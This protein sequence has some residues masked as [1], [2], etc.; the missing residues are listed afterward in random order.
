MDAPTHSCPPI[1][2]PRPVM[3]SI[4]P[5]ASP[6]LWWLE[7]VS[8]FYGRIYFMVRGSITPGIRAHSVDAGALA[9]RSRMPV[10]PYS[11]DPCLSLWISRSDYLVFQKAKQA[12]ASFGKPKRTPTTHLSF[13]RPSFSSY[14]QARRKP[15]RPGMLGRL[16]ERSI[17]V[18][19]KS[20]NDFKNSRAMLGKYTISRVNARSAPS[21][22]SV[23]IK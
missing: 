10:P 15:S 12:Q 4:P 1:Q 20:V 9:S 2:L 18:V 14:L 21:R 22:G 13:R 16:A 5:G 17:D 6:H 19:G 3:S 7:D 8:S 23:P 11:P